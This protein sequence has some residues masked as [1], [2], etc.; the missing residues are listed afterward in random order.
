M[1]GEGMNAD[2]GDEDDYYVEDEDDGS[3]PLSHHEAG[4]PVDAGDAPV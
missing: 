4:A 2:E 1:L 3:R